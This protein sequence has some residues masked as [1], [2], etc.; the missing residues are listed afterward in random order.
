MNVTTTF[1]VKDP[2]L[3][4]LTEDI[5]LRAAEITPNLFIRQMQANVAD[6]A[7]VVNSVAE[8]N[9][10]LNKTMSSSL[11][12]LGRVIRIHAAGVYSNDA[13]GSN[14]IQFRI[15]F[16][17][18]NIIVFDAITVTSSNTNAPWVIEAYINTKSLGATG[19]V[20]G[21]GTLHV[22]HGGGSKVITTDIQMDNSTVTVD[23]RAAHA[24]QVSVQH[25]VAHADT[26]S[27]LENFI[28]DI[29]Q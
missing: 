27:T 7:E 8:N 28:V 18:T 17:A 22:A 23:T 2:A 1:E 19:S 4:R 21:H 9:Y 11:L 20:K 3:L 12:K 16:G 6:S 25:G 5:R 24:L 13:A 10:S 14:T 15:K 26:K 29:L